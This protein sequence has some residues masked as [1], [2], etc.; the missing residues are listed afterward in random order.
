MTV[1]AFKA[2]LD[3]DIEFNTAFEAAVIKMFNVPLSG[4][5]R[6]LLYAVNVFKY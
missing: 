4:A 5:V 2:L 6:V 3:C 1:E